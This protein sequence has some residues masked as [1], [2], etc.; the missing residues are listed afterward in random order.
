MELIF[1]SYNSWKIKSYFVMHNFFWIAFILPK[2]SGKTLLSLWQ[3]RAPK[4]ILGKLVLQQ[5]SYCFPE[6]P[7]I[8]PGYD[9]HPIT[10]PNTIP[11]L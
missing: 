1:W 8:F 9:P 5:N 2:K 10:I 3:K 7:D 6:I 4:V 11:L